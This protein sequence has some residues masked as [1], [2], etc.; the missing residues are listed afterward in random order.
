MACVWENVKDLPRRL[1]SELAGIAARTPQCDEFKGRKPSAT[2]ETVCCLGYA[3]GRIYW[4]DP[5]AAAYADMQISRGVVHARPYQDIWLYLPQKGICRI[6][7]GL[8]P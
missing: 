4:A 3:E 8:L 5:A 1:L 7:S 2:E 6:Q